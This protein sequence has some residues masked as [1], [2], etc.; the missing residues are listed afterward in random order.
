M[1]FVSIS[2]QTVSFVLYIISRLVF[3][4]KVESVHSA[5]QTEALY[6]VFQ[7]E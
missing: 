2:E 1:C 3:V 4:T 7:E 6:R 5:V